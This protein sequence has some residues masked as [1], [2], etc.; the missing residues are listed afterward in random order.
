MGRVCCSTPNLCWQFCWQYPPISHSYELINQYPI[1]ITRRSP[2]FPTFSAESHHRSAG[3]PRN[4]AGAGEAKGQLLRLI[5]VQGSVDS[6]RMLLSSDPLQAIFDGFETSL[7]YDLFYMYTVYIYISPSSLFIAP[8]WIMCAYWFPPFSQRWI[9]CFFWDFKVE[10]KYVRR[11]FCDSWTF[12]KSY[13]QW[14]GWWENLQESPIC[15]GKIY[16]FL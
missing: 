2:S 5:N 10:G 7:V 8:C 12:R 11:R 14:I 15:D 6:L 1:A 13:T 3:S 16:G 9:A 4:S